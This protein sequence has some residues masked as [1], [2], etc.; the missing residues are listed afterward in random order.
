MGWGLE[1][2][3]LVLLI[4]VFLV[5]ND[6]HFGFIQTTAVTT[7]DSKEQEEFRLWA[8]PEGRTG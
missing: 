5:E 1:L 8:R 7:Q 4:I 2:K 3:S 6:W